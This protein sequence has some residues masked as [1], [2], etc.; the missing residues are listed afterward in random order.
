MQFDMR[1]RNAVKLTTP[2]PPHPVLYVPTGRW[3]RDADRE[4]KGRV[5]SRS[6]P[7]CNGRSSESQLPLTS[8]VKCMRARLS[9]RNRLIVT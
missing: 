9:D 7:E 2:P 3:M 6:T 4:G 1:L 8:G 5:I